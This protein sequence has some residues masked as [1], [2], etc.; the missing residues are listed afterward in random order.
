MVRYLYPVFL[1][2]LSGLLQ[3]PNWMALRKFILEE[4]SYSS[5]WATMLLLDGTPSVGQS[6]ILALTTVTNMTFLLKLLKLNQSNEQNSCQRIYSPSVM[7]W[8]YM[9][10]TRL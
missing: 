9:A 7:R 1:G 8:I 3:G 2:Y 10:N 6:I 5:I 4:R